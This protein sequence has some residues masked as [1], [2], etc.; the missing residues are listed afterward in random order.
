[1]TQRLDLTLPDS[2]QPQW[3]IATNHNL[4]EVDLDFQGI[5]SELVGSD[6]ELMVGL[7]NVAGNLDDLETALDTLNVEALARAEEQ[8]SVGPSGAILVAGG[9]FQF[10]NTTI[11]DNNR[12][13][14]KPPGTAPCTYANEILTITVDLLMASIAGRP[15]LLNRINKMISVPDTGDYMFILSTRA[16]DGL[17]TPY[18]RSYPSLGTTKGKF[19]YCPNVGTPSVALDD[20]WKPRAGDTLIIGDD[21]WIIKTVAIDVIEVLDEMHDLPDAWGP[22]WSVYAHYEPYHGVVEY[23]ES[24]WRDP[25]VVVVAIV[26]DGVLTLNNSINAGYNAMHLGATVVTGATGNATIVSNLAR[27]FTKCACRR[28]RYISSG[29]RHELVFNGFNK[30]LTVDDLPS[31]ITS[32]SA[33]DTLTVAQQATTAT[34]YDPRTGSSVNTST[35][36]STTVIVGV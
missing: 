13:W 32:I 20:D 2:N 29:A 7:N 14:T 24:Y 1:M 33:E 16:I 36:T 4:E 34:F 28:Y 19:L 27:C 15:Y 25:T 8:F 26:S 11:E 22:A 10:G 17:S 35:V 12:W 3:G 5:A 21:H 23:D 31:A 18:R 6:L 30:V 9:A